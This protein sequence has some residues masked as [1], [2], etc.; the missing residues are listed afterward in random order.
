MESKLHLEQECDL[1]RLK[2]LEMAASCQKAIS[3]A[4]QAYVD[5]NTEMA[6]EVIDNDCNINELQYTIDEKALRLMALDQPV[7]RDLRFVL[8]CTYIASNLER[9]GDQAVNISERALLLAQRPALPHNPL[10]A[11]LSDTAQAMLKIVIEAF[12]TGDPD[13]AQK[14]CEMDAKAD[15][16]NLKILTHYI[17]YM[18]Q[19]SRSVERAVHNIISAKCLER[20]GDLATNIAENIIFI[21]KGIDIRQ[22][23]RPY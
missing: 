16:L 22:T 1:L 8:G 11:E 19:E 23:C 9:V 7:A 3:Q 18:I 15:T 13:L 6:Q 17:D 21:I 20:V 2:V 12:N 14:V 10:M 4:L 5:R